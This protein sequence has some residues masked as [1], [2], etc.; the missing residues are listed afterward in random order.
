LSMQVYQDP[1]APV[2]ERVTDLLGRMTPEEKVGQMM[3]LPA[4]RPGMTDLLETQHI[5]SFLHCTGEMMSE[6]Q[7]RA[8]KTRLSIPLIFG[9]DAIHGHCF[10]PNGTV[11][12][13]QLAMACAWDR[14]LL[15]RIGRATASEVRA[16]G[17]H[18]T[19]SPVLCVGRD[20][21]WG[22]IDETFGED[23]WLT[24]ELAAELIA[25]YQGSGPDDPF[26]PVGDFA[27]EDRVLAC[28]KHLAAYGETTGGRDAYEAEVS[29]RKLLSLFLPPFEKAVKRAGCA[30]LMTAYQAIDGVPCTASRWLLRETVK[31][32]WAT[33]GFI[34]TDWNN[35][36]ALHDRQYVARDSREAALLAIAA[37]NDMVMSTPSFYEDA[38]ALIADGQVEMTLI[39]DSVSRILRA[40]FRLGLFD[41]LR[42]PDPKRKT[43]VVGAKK[44]RQAALDAARESLVLLKNAPPKSA[45][46][47]PVLPIRTAIRSVL[48]TG[49][50]ADDVVAQLGDWS[51]GSMQVGAEDRSFHRGQT[52]TIRHGLESRCEKADIRCIYE[53]GVATTG[54]LSGDSGDAIEGSSEI[55]EEERSAINSAAEAA[56]SVDL[57]VV[58][59]GDTLKQHG[60]YR[61]RGILSL[62]AAQ[63]AL[64]EAMTTSGKPVVV[65]YLA[66]KPL[67]IGYVKHAADALICCFNP[68]EAGGTA[69]AEVLFGDVNP[70]GKLPISFPV[71]EGQLP[72]HYNRYAGWH[73]RND[74][75]HDGYERYYDLP[76][77]PLFAFGE[78]YTYTEF[79]YTELEVETPILTTPVELKP[80][81][82]GDG[83]MI[84][85]GPP[86]RVQF[87]ITNTG[88]REGT[89]IAQLYIRD[90][91]SSVTR[92]VKELRGFARVTL[93]P[94]ESSRISLAVSYDDLAL[95]D[96]DLTRRVEPGRFEVMVGGSS[97]DEHLL[98]AGFEVR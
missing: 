88:E 27:F 35:V 6:L 42:H 44:H 39:D 66:S 77:E 64:L 41:E 80:G 20:P 36:G 53:Q 54:F 78:G 33:D 34:V 63:E 97:R 69:V 92:P 79:S 47:A 81:N 58:V 7:V 19:F 65:V 5:G 28:A 16:T 61:D 86:L 37:G 49:P 59:I 57:I 89:E 15:R 9:I 23:P 50:N 93:Q 83:H 18:W 14:S 17:N 84:E 25:G 2:E 8:E 40:K 91:Y 75:G 85:G 21:R 76:G 29:R 24:G 11:F 96:G 98:R 67:A 70:A 10:E 30:T 74:G 71:H 13:T 4:N 73:A 38:L 94:G 32:K 72:V 68:G 52:T 51:F 48:V 62:G 60:E 95:V 90:L 46:D 12:P 1:K 43:A 26:D 45:P 31:E 82:R 22:R 87:T 55:S 56:R 3:Q